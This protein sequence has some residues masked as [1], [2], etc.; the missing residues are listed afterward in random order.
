MIRKMCPNSHQWIRVLL[1]VLNKYHNSKLLSFYILGFKTPTQKDKIFDIQQTKENA[2]SHKGKI[3]KAK[4]VGNNMFTQR[5]Q[6]NDMLTNKIK[7][8]QT[9]EKVE[10]ITKDTCFACDA[11]TQTVQRKKTVCVIM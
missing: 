7:P 11:C 3:E 6:A 10:I 4:D 8:T 5:N 1:Q 9:Q 2:K